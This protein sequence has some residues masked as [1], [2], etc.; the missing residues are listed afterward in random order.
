MDVYEIN[1]LIEWLEGLKRDYGLSFICAQEMREKLETM[2][3]TPPK[4]D[5]AGEVVKRLQ[6]LPDWRSN[7]YRGNINRMDF[8]MG[9]SRST[10]QRWRDT[11]VIASTLPGIQYAHL[12][13]LDKRKERNKIALGDL[14]AAL[15]HAKRV[16][17]EDTRGKRV[18]PS[19]CEEYLGVN[20]QLYN[21]WL[22]QTCRNPKDLEGWISWLTGKIKELSR[23]TR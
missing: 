11:G 7:S 20:K 17:N 12:R 14:R 15:K 19:N 6:G 4:V 16:F 3:E 2:R 18:T 9:I 21:N 22:R 13:D 8:T 1:G 5:K 10:S 23:V